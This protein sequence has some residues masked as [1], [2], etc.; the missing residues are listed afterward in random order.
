MAAIQKLNSIDIQEKLGLNFHSLSVSE[1]LEYG[2][3]CSSILLLKQMFL[4]SS[5]CSWFTKVFKYSFS[6]KVDLGTDV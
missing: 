6:K 4:K 5:K 3:N 1:L 2:Q